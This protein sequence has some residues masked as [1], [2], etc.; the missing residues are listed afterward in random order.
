VRVEQFKSLLSF[1]DCYE[2]RSDGPDRG[3]VASEP[4]QQQQYFCFLGYDLLGDETS[5]NLSGNTYSATYNGAGRLTGF[6]ATDY[7]D[8][9]NPASLLSSGEYDAFGHLISATFAN[10]LSQSWAY[11][12]R[13]RP[14]A[15]AV[16]TTCSAGTCSGSTVYSYG[17]GYTADSDLLSATDSV[18]G[19]WSYTYDGFNRLATSNCS[20]NCPNGSSIEG[21]SY[22]YD[23]YSNRWNQTVTA[24]SGGS[25]LLTFNGPGNVLNNR[26][27]GYSYDAAGNLLNDTFHSYAYDAENRI[28]AVDA[29]TT[30]GYDAQ[31]RRVSKTAGGSVTD[32]IYDREGHMILTN[33]ATPTLIELMPP[34]YTWERIS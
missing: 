27:D 16:G 11:D 20:A 7:T 1:N 25:S 10:N 32:F 4:C 28:L 22:G 23:R 30:Y 15:M 17:V 18:N 12:N 3:T 29:A 26:I 21:F 13:G 34:D 9:T 14:H 8:S 31:D 19:T 2:L 6:T 24:G 33:P 5:R